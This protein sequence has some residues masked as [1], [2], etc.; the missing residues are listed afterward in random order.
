MSDAL[1]YPGG[2]FV[3]PAEIGKEERARFI[4]QIAEMPALLRRAVEG[5]SPEQLST[6]YRPGGWTVRQVVH[7]IPDS[8][9][10][11]YA[12]TK[13]ALTEEL[14]TVKTY[15]QED[16][17]AAGDPR[18]P[19]EAPLRLLEGL[20]ELW[21]GLLRSLSEE[22]WRRGF[23]HPE[24]AGPPAPNEGQ[25]AE[26]W[27]RAFVSDGRGVVTVESL[28]ATYAWHGRHHTAQITSLRERMG[29]N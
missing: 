19:V 25:D 6:P 13:L 23:V 4:E 8:H 26:P 17:A 20:H 12:R 22:Q 10:N 27:R 24:L 18:V 9:L 2:E 1:R 16:W 5:L 15:N 29:W 7:H 21:A 28:L 3:A 14:P 11:A